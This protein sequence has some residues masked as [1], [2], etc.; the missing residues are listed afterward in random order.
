VG[1]FLQIPIRL[2]DVNTDLILTHLN[3]LLLLITQIKKIEREQTCRMH[4]TEEEYL[5]FS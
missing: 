1:V 2:N 5:R 3:K 4:E